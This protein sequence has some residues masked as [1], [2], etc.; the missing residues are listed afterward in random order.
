[1]T[2]KRHLVMLAFMVLALGLS[3]TTGSVVTSAGCD[4]SDCDPSDC[5]AACQI[6]SAEEC[7]AVCPPECIV[8]C[9]EPCASPNQASADCAP[10]CN[11]NVCAM[12]TRASGTLAAIDPAGQLSF[13]LATGQSAEIVK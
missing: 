3:F 1:M 12:G 6:M 4:P 9:D 7:A 13:S 8:L 10:G 5:A 2:T 11:L